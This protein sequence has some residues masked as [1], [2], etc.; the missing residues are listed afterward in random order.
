M[1][2]IPRHN[3]IKEL[4]VQKICRDLKDLPE[5]AIQIGETMAKIALLLGS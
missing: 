4:I 1:I 5:T 2:V 3:E